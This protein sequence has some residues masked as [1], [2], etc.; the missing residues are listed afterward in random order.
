MAS[1]RMQYGIGTLAVGLIAA[2]VA[3]GANAMQAEPVSAAVVN[4]QK[5]F[6]NLKERE[7]IQA[8]M[9][10]RAQDL[11][12]QEKQRRKKIQQMKSDLDIMEP[13]SQAY[14]EQQSKLEQ[15]V[16]DLQAWQQFKQQKVKRSRGVQLEN[17]YRKTLRA[18]EDVANEKGYDVVLYK[19]GAP[20]FNF[21]NQ[22]QLSTMIQVRKVLWSKDKLDITQQIIQ[23]MNNEFQNSGGN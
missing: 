21:Q 20:D 14:K 4:V 17:L 10:Q 13:G 15:A 11:Q 22:R 18:I 9:R 6:S 1:K 23:R 7:Q 3:Y 16:I 12:D 2:A 8:E 19:E 5:V